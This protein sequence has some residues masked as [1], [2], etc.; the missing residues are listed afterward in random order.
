MLPCLRLL[1]C[2]FYV[3]CSQLTTDHVHWSSTVY[4][5]AVPAHQDAPTDHTTLIAGVFRALYMY[6][7]SVNGSSFSI[8]FPTSHLSNPFWY[9]LSHIS[10][11]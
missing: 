6:R 1:V 7:S 5:D 2:G 11:L 9:L 4:V 10:P 3:F 8:L